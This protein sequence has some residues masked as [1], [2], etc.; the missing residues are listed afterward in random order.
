MFEY[1]NA[2][3]CADWKLVISTTHKKNKCRIWPE[4]LSVNARIK[5][6]ALNKLSLNYVQRFAADC[7]FTN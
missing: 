5:K 4:S 1:I 3:G 2:K 6:R 7:A